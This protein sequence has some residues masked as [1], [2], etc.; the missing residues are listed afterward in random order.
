MCDSPQEPLSVSD[1]F[2]S[3]V[4]AGKMPIVTVRVQQT[5]RAN[6]QIWWW[7]EE[8]SHANLK[9]STVLLVITKYKPSDKHFET[10]SYYTLIDKKTGKRFIWKMLY[11]QIP[12]SNLFKDLHHRDF[13]PFRLI[14]CFIFI[15][16]NTL[17]S[18]DTVNYT[19]QEK[20][21]KKLY[22]FCL[23]QWSDF[24]TSLHKINW[25]LFICLF[26][27][28]CLLIKLEIFLQSTKE[29]LCNISNYL[30]EVCVCFFVLPA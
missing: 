10:H 16:W 28:V 17:M 20:N 18:E 4:T 22:C 21:N 24:F 12:L 25:V 6:S 14:C 3:A 2:V 13:L 29:M 27:S 11:K 9:K 15:V 5:E 23:Q 19:L 1:V 8:W 26:F 30:G 7:E